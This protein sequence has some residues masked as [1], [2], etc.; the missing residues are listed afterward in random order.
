LPYFLRTI[1][2][3]VLS[4]I[5]IKLSIENHIIHPVNPLNPQNPAQISTD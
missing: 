1:T 3:V 5:E 4:R 2:A